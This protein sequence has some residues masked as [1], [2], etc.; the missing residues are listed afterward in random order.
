MMN[1]DFK[2]DFRV[3]EV[4]RIVRYVE[5]EARERWPAVRRLFIRPMDGAGSQVDW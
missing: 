2:D 5:E 4:E 1:V 3:G